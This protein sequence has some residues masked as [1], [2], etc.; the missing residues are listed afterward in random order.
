MVG[1][2]A[3]RA[4]AVTCGTCFSDTA[5][6]GAQC[7]EAHFEK[8]KSFL[9]IAA[10]ENVQTVAGGR[11]EDSEELAKGYFIRPTIYADVDQNS[12]L[13]QEEIFGP[14]LVVTRF[15]SDEEAVKLANDSQYGLAAGLWT[16]NIS[17]AHRIAA[18]LEAG[19]IFINRYGC[20]DFSSPFGGYKMSGWG[21]E[22]GKHSLEAYTKTKS[23]WVAL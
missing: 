18:Q 9:E 19:M 4:E 10:T 13:V 12:R 3:E 8:I 2:L 6:Q 14:V 23:I 17:R 15:K 21:K 22:M 1:E 16:A 5:Y 11:V 20:Y 7:N